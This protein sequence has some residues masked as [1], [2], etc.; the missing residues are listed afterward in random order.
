MRHKRKICKLGRNKS[1]RKSL[2]VNL[3]ISLFLN[4]KVETTP[5][6]AKLVRSMAEKLITIGRKAGIAYDQRIMSILGSP[7]MV[8]VVKAVAEKYIDRQGGYTRIV[9]LPPRRGD[10]APMALIQFV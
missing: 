7:D 6:R 3:T 9:K 5:A 10:A 8:K 1:Q 4:K 2:V